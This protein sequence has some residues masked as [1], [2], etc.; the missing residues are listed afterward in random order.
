MLE[1]SKESRKAHFRSLHQSTVSGYIYEG[2]SALQ[3]GFASR[4]KAAEGLC[5]FR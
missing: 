1:A 3:T 5:Q 4:G 2:D